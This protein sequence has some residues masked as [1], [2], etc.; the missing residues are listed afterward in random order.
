MRRD[1]LA[2]VLRYTL[3]GLGCSSLFSQESKNCPWPT[4][5]QAPAVNS[6]KKRDWFEKMTFR[7]AELDEVSRLLA[8]CALHRAGGE[9]FVSVKLFRTL[10]FCSKL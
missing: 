2:A 4:Y 6:K 7:T 5:S 8:V 3:P 1:L 10:F 9:I